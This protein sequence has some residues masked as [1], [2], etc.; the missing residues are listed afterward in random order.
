MTDSDVNLDADRYSVCAAD[1]EPLI[2]TFVFPFKE[3]ICLVCG[4][5]YE[6]FGAP[7]KE[8]TPA[9]RARLEELMAEWNRDYMDRG[10]LGPSVMLRDCETCRKEHEPH[11]RH[12]TD[13]ERAAND[14]AMS[15]LAARAAA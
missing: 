3:W 15:R 13:E 2:P 7:M 10:L 12:A 11:L 14:D 9:L 4:R 8:R 1:G 6:F 5:K